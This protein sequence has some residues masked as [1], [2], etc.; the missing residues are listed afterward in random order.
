MSYEQ[1]VGSI[2]NIHLNSSCSQILLSLSGVLVGFTVGFGLLTDFQPPYNTTSTAILKTFTMMGGELSFDTDHDSS[3]LMGCIIFIFFIIF[4]SVIMTNVMLAIAVK[5][6]S[7]LE[8]QGN[9][10]RL[11]KQT[12]YLVTLENMPFGEIIHKNISRRNK[13]VSWKNIEMV[14]VIYPG[15]IG[16]ILSVWPYKVYKKILKIATENRKRSE[17]VTTR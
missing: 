2:V 9:A 8:S 3:T 12:Q 14:E 10:R 16:S 4:V 15:R 13:Q 11:M 17:D 1:Y 6:I 5:D 7:A